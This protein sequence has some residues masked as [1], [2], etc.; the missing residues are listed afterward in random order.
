MTIDEAYERGVHD[1]V[2]QEGE[3]LL[4]RIH[5][6]IRSWEAEPDDNLRGMV[7]AAFEVFSTAITH[8][9]VTREQAI[10]AALKRAKNGPRPQ[11]WRF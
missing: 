7:Q 8:R 3:R 9:G 2:Q 10:T 5:D 4:A 11:F 6:V 1:G